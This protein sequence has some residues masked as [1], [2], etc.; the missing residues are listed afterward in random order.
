VREWSRRLLW[1]GVKDGTVKV[2]EN[3]AGSY[4]NAFLISGVLCVVAAVPITVVRPP[5][6][7]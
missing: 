2:M 5:K 4:L 1:S 3:A 7:H 6:A